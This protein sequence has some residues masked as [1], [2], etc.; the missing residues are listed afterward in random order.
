MGRRRAR[1]VVSSD[2]EFETLEALKENTEWSFD[3]DTKNIPTERA[4]PVSV[5][6]PYELVYSGHERVIQFESLVLHRKKIEQVSVWFEQ[7]ASRVRAG[8]G[9]VLLVTGPTGSGKTALV[10][11]LCHRESISVIDGYEYQTRQK[12]VRK[13]STIQNAAYPSLKLVPDQADGH[14]DSES[15]YVAAPRVLLVDDLPNEDAS[16]CVEDILSIYNAK[17]LQ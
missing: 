3:F 16:D 1:L 8:Q 11:S 2:S 7:F 12:C 5:A 6:D 13:K 17:G 4:R 14:L 15:S 9:S 10:R